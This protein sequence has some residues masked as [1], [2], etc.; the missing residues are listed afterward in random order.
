MHLFHGTTD[1][2]LSSIKKYGLKAPDETG[3]ITE[4]RKDNKCFVFLTDNRTYAEVYAL[5]AVDKFG[6]KPV[7]L[8]CDVDAVVERLKVGRGSNQYMMLEW[9]KLVEVCKIEELTPP[10]PF[11]RRK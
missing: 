3:N 6:G 7:V 4:K 10:D 2:F 9:K 1:L 8:I 5:R 11:G